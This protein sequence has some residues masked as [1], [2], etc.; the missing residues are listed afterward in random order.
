MRRGGL[1]SVGVKKL[2]GGFAKD[3]LS[4]GLFFGNKNSYMKF[5]EPIKIIIIAP[6]PILARNV[7]PFLPGYPLAHAMTYKN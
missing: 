7:S 3:W 6:Q 1:W 5:G 2:E 4:T